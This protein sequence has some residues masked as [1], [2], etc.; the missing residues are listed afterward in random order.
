MKAAN[1]TSVFK[2][3]IKGITLIVDQLVYYQTC[4]KFLKRC[5][6]NQLYPF[7]LKKYFLVSYA[8]FERISVFNFAI[9]D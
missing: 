6:Y 7:F 2:K 1:I 5:L 8:N 4:Q 9:A 3:M